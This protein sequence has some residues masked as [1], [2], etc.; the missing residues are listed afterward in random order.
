MHLSGRHA[1]IDV[2]L[3]GIRFTR[4]ESD[5]AKRGTKR[6]REVGWDQVAGAT[7]QTNRKGRA[8][9]RVTVAGA[10]AVDHH[11]DDPYAVKLR[12]GQTAAA[13]ELVGE[14]NT[15]VAVR[16]RWREQSRTTG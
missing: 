7:V 2:S 11:R 8:I 16:L 5:A 15:E 4:S 13:Q 14:I 10:Q 6:V 12:R 3:D 9:I 1:R